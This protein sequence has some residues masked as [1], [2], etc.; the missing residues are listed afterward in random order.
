MHFCGGSR[1]RPGASL[2]LPPDLSL[3]CAGPGRQ[4]PTSC[5]AV[6]AHLPPCSHE[7]PTPLP[8]NAHKRDGQGAHT[9]TLHT[10]QPPPNAVFTSPGSVQATRSPAP[11]TLPPPGVQDLPGAGRGRGPPDRQPTLLAGKQGWVAG[12]S[13]LALEDGLGRAPLFPDP[14]GQPGEAPCACARGAGAGLQRGRG[15]LLP[16]PLLWCTGQLLWGPTPAH[17]PTHS[18]PPPNPP[19][20]QP[21]PTTSPQTPGPQDELMG[22]LSAPGAV[23]PGSLDPLTPERRAEEQVGAPAGPPR[24]L[25]RARA[26]GCAA[27]IT[28]SVRLQYTQTLEHALSPPRPP[29][30]PP[31]HGPPP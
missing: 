22:E 9:H 25:R 26:P 16:G 30:H 6:P 2:N 7:P 31:T 14:S 10:S 11:P 8:R 20:H 24:A 1:L 27:G 5:T 17:P 12:A 15:T 13:P 28:C 3:S 21:L 29:P 19:P 23:A 18:Q 4:A